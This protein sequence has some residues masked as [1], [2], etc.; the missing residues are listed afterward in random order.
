MIIGPDM[1]CILKVSHAH[2]GSLVY[3]LVL[4][5]YLLE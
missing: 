3:L 5:V 4:V 2:A 1:P